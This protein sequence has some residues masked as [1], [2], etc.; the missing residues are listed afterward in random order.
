MEFQGLELRV[1]GPMQWTAS[2]RRL[3][4]GR[5]SGGCHGSLLVGSDC[6]RQRSIDHQSFHVHKRTCCSHPR[7]HGF[8]RSLLSNTLKMG[9]RSGTMASERIATCVLV[10]FL[11]PLALQHVPGADRTFASFIS[12]STGMSKSHP[13]QRSPVVRRVREKKLRFEGKQQMEA[14][15]AQVRHKP[16]ASIPVLLD[17]F[18][19]AAQEGRLREAEKIYHLLCLPSTESQFTINQA[20]INGLIVAAGKCGDI[21]RAKHWFGQ[22]WAFDL[23]PNSEI[24]TSMISAGAEYGDTKFAEEYFNA[25]E[26][27]QV[28][29][30]LETYGAMIKAAANAKD[31]PSAEKWFYQSQKAGLQPSP[32]QFVSVS[33]TSLAQICEPFGLQRIS[34]RMPVCHSLWVVSS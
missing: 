29:P 9:L 7:V 27:F 11:W 19:K 6:F 31:L 25:M 34:S 1:Y 13:R 2:W 30:R 3:G 21:E 15:R 28:A 26:Y 20:T 16:G 8:C 18:H 12:T 4:S 23:H 33:R 24:F 14:R 17:R 22:L 5:T 32:I 10:W